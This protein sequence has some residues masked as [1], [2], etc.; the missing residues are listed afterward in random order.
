MFV[1]VSCSARASEGALL[2]AVA[3][4]GAAGSEGGGGSDCKS[5]AKLRQDV[6]LLEM[7]VEDMGAAPSPG[8]FTPKSPII[9]SAETGRL[10]A[11]LEEKEVDTHNAALPIY[12]WVTVAFRG[13]L[14]S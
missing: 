10:K 11:K 4:G 3:V 2:E 6:Q 5:C 9:D 8:G 7:R 12:P 13:Q 14:P 1:F